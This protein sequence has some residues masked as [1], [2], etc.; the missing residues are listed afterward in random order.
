MYLNRMHSFPSFLL[1]F[2]ELLSTPEY[3]REEQ[4]YTD[5]HSKIQ[6][7]LVC[8]VTGKACILS[9]RFTHFFLLSPIRKVVPS[10]Y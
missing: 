7:E 8:K 4:L 5:S 10:C 3:E 9:C 2:T 1:D 6:E